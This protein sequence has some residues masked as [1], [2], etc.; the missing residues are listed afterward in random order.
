V[1]A[2]ESSARPGDAALDDLAAPATRMLPIETRVAVGVG[3]GLIGGAFTLLGLLL[4]FWAQMTGIMVAVFLIPIMLVASW[5]AFA[6]Q[7]RRMRDDK[8]AQLL[9]L[10][11]ALKLLG[12]L[13]RYWVALH[14]YGGNADAVY[15][16]QTGEDLAARFRAGDFNTAPYSL[17]GTDF[18]TVFTG[19]LYTVT[20]PSIFAGFLFY[21]WLAFAGMFY[22]YRAFVIAVPDGNSRSY[23]MLLFFLP[24]MLYW[25][26]SIGKE[27]W[28]LFT[29]GL[30]AFGVARLLTGRPWRGMLL[31]GVGFWLGTLVR[32]H[33]VGMA[34]LGMVVAYLLA[35]PPRRMGMLG[36]VVK[37]LALVVLVALAVLLLGQTEAYLKQKGI[38]PQ[39]GVSS[40]LGETARR[41]GTGGSNFQVDVRGP[42]P[43][44][45]PIAVV[46]ILFRPFPFEAHNA[47]AAVTALESFLLLCLTI[48]RRRAVWQAVRHPRR[49]PYVAFILVYLVLFV[50]AFSTIANFGILA[51]ERTQ[52]LPF[53]LVLLVIP[54]GRRA[55]STRP[56]TAAVEDGRVDADR[57]L[58][59]T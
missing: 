20:G 51:R 27:A 19:I 34:A 3:S 47:Q 29:L 5:P 10:A 26:S 4:L 18:M 11:L 41:T 23:A 57:Q 14:I 48:S 58:A 8:L 55:G 50:F 31:A 37:L 49:R 54:A 17:S 59:G 16:H 45:F 39:D 15:Y 1:A 52:L 43:S 36:P 38:E 2:T 30:V 24:S 25:P 28:M 22:M 7:A 13:V 6:R 12:S 42:S 33:V 44:Q 35:R 32:P 21:S 53:F 46:T 40:V 9:L 56:A